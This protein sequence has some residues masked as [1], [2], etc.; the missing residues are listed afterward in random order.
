MH[1]SIFDSRSPVLARRRYK[2]LGGKLRVSTSCLRYH[3]EWAVGD[4][5]RWWAMVGDEWA[6]VGDER[7]IIARQV[8]LV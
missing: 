5:G 4:G 7:V 6:M 1:K 2:Q 3:Q 8:F